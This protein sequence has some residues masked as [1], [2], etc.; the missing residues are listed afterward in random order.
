MPVE[1]RAAGLALACRDAYCSK[2]VAPK[3]LLCE[4]SELPLPSRLLATWPELD[5]R[6]LSLELN[7]S[8]EEV[9]RLL[10][11]PAPPVV[12]AEG[13]SAPLP[14]ASSSTGDGGAATVVV[15]SLGFDANGSVR[16]WV[17]E[18]PPDLLPAQP[19]AASFAGV[20]AK[21]R[22]RAGTRVV[23][24]ADARAPH[25]QVVALIDALK[26]VG[27]AHVAMQ[28]TPS[29]EPRSEGH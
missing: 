21:A 18:D 2:F 6:I 25:G 26:Q 4:S 9:A 13:P 10:P 14:V 3:P 29:T 20:A 15:V 17:D 27:F 5:M 8:L 24:A 16:A 22:K 7:V 28:V 1:A 19:S 12:E 23:V 11:R